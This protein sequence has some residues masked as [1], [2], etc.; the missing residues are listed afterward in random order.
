MIAAVRLLN[1]AR[2]RE[3]P[4][5]TA[6]TI[7]AIGSGVALFVA[8]LVARSSAMGALHDFDR[9]RA[10]PATLAVVGSS[11]SAGL[12][13]S[14]LPKVERTPGVEAAVPM[15]QTVTIAENAS[16]DETFVVALGVDCRIEAV[17]GDVGCSD[18]PFT[19]VADGPLVAPGL[20]RS[21]GSGGVIR[22][23]Q[24]RVPIRGAPTL[25]LLDD[26]NGGRVVVFPLDRAQDLFTRV[27][28]YDLILVVPEPGVS[29]H[30]LR[31]RLV[32]R[33]GRNNQVS[34]TGGWTV[35]EQ[36]TLP[37]LFLL[38]MVSLVLGGQLA[39]NAISL[40]LAERRRDLAV[41]GALGASGRT[42]LAG[43]LLE[44][45]LLGLAGGVLGVGGGVLAARPL[46]TSMSTYVSRSTGVGL[47]VHMSLGLAATG[48][49]IGVGVAV[50][51]AVRPARRA[52]RADIA[53][54][55]HARGAPRPEVAPRRGRRALAC[56]VLG[57]AGLGL[58]WIGQRDGALEPWQPLVAELGLVAV[59]LF[60]LR[61]TMHG[62]APLLRIVSGRVRRFQRGLLGV[63]TDNLV[64][65]ARRTG[66]MTLV[67]AA[68][69]SVGVL[70]GGI[71]QV[72]PAGAARFVS[73]AAPGAIEVSGTSS[74]VNAGALAGDPSPKVRARIEQLPGVASVAG[75]YTADVHHPL[76][77]EQEV[78]FES[79]DG[80]PTSRLPIVRGD[81][82]D[83]VLARGEV[84]IGPVIARAY[85]LSVGDTF[86]VP[87]RSGVATL[88]VGA[89]VGEDGDLG[90]STTIPYDTF[91]RLF[92]Q[93]A[94]GVLFVIPE[95][96]VSIDALADRIR[97]EVADL[98]P[99]LSVLPPD[100]LVD[101]A[102]SDVGAFITPFWALQRS[103]MLVALLAALSTLL[104]VGLER[105][106]EYG[107]LAAVGLAPTSLGRMVVLEAGIVGVLGTILGTLIAFTGLI[108]VW[109][110]GPVL[111]GLSA[112]GRIDLVAPL[113]YGLLTTG[114]VVVGAALPAWRASRLDPATALR[115]E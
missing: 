23:D 79:R 93:R 16:G 3:H 53:A 66:T 62:A 107:L 25:G 48:V 110:V 45:G 71:Q 20:R 39:Y 95:D 70:L 61:G 98:D 82:A 35:A 84:V 13:E 9:Q 86:E 106:R 60:P 38:G 22:T 8:V 75:Y 67:V 2:L 83:A 111:L 17:V 78:M 73:R 64:G 109:M 51:A 112:P 44:A 88:R 36:P 68:A 30:A 102:A 50:L 92:G 24:G 101:R 28:A 42:L 76:L 58:A 47:E 103:L 100:E 55:L 41:S 91:E 99:D 7:V 56:G 105:R 34:E 74:Q 15:V 10:G 14:V 18:E 32:E 26:F 52:V 77:G 69:V 4:L 11:A 104:L 54:E 97:T 115:Y 87:G 46:V 81:S 80:P 57:L 33:I 40:S 72:I 49:V 12:D 89:I 94:P 29:D 114:A 90:E 96:G 21:L 37:M 113:V 43:T 63:A 19:D 6:L 27:R 59:V 65:D 1:L 31:Q 5:R 85:D 108:A